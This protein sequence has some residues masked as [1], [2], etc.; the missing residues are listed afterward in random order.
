MNESLKCPFRVG[1][2]VRY[3]PSARGLADD[4]MSPPEHR[5]TLGT[6]YR[7][8]RI[9]D[10]SYIAVEGY[11]HPGGGLYWTEFSSA[12]KSETDTE[13]Q[14]RSTHDSNTRNA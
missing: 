10:D 9:Q 5:L 3:T 13:A 2:E 6:I 14:S 7:I 12:A 11:Q 8:A 1:D 4:V